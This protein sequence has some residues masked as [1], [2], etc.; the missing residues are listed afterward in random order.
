MSKE[1]AKK[2]IAELRTSKELQAKIADAE[3]LDEMV[4]IAV[5]A[6]Y[7]VTL[8]EMLE[9]EKE[10]KAEMNAK[11]EELTADELE[12]VAGGSLWSGEEDP[13]GNEYGCAVCNLGYDDQKEYG[14]WCRETYFCDQVNLKVPSSDPDRRFKRKRLAI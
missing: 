1:T 7:D 6:G 10:F 3:S 12:N 13:D 11:T 9:A 14:D 2:L 4:K 8:E 5:G